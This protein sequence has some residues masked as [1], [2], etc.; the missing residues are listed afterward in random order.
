MENIR[1]E[2]LK[3]NLRQ[4][5]VAEYLELSLNTYSRKEKQGGFTDKELKVLASKYGCTVDYLIQN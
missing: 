5:D 2:R 4:L 3:R 1:I